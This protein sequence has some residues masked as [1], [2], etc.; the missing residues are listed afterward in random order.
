[1]D[2]YVSIS[3]DG[4]C[5]M[6]VDGGRQTIVPELGVVLISSAEI[7]RLIHGSGDL[8]SDEFVEEGIFL[9]SNITCARFFYTL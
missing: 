3:P 2:E 1:M 8:H 9:F 4:T 7:F 5:E 6:C